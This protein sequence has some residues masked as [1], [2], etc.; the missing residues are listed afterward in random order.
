MKAHAERILQIWREAGEPWPI[1][2]LFSAHGLPETVVA[3]GDPYQA[4]IEASAVAVLERIERIPGEIGIGGFATRAA[5][6]R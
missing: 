6:A 1:R 4:Q 3:R 2:L 5:S